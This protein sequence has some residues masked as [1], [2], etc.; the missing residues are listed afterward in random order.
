[1]GNQSQTALSSILFVHLKNDSYEPG[2]LASGLAIMVIL[3]GVSRHS[4]SLLP[5]KLS[6]MS[7]LMTNELTKLSTKAQKCE[8]LGDQ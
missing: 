4:I 2:V 3:E 8:E 6:S 1:M 5:K 7:F